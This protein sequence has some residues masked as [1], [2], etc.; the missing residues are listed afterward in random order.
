MPIW[1]TT[2]VDEIPEIKL[3]SWKVY[4]VSSDLWPEK[5]RHFVG[6]NITESEGRVSSSIV[7][8]DKSTMRG[9]TASGRVYELVGSPGHSRDADYTWNRWR[10]M[11]SIDSVEEVQIENS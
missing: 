5:T 4:E 6:W 8:F 1:L 3:R 10:K 11:N 9:R 2:P 7:E